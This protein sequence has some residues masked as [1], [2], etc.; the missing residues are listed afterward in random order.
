MMIA[1]NSG[2]LCSPGKTLS[3]LL[4][5]VLC[6]LALVF[7][8][9]SA[10]EWNIIMH[11][12][13]DTNT[14]TSVAIIKNESGY[15]LEIYKDSVNAVRARFTLSKGLISFPDSFCPTFQIDSGR[16]KNHSVNDAPCLSSNTWAEFIL[17]YVENGQINSSAI[18]GLM[19]G[20][21]LHFRFL[22][23]NDNYRETLFTLRGSK[24][25][26]LAALGE[27]ISITPVNP[28]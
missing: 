15:T 17:G 28:Y 19:N 3:A 8:H 4:V 9:V 11:N 26:M 18:V 22:L 7:N 13:M 1:L 21:G 6:Y 5:I 10:A 16:P 23:E 25:A 12:D 2:P 24:R 20:V 14:I 27:G